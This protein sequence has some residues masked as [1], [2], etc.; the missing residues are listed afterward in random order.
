MGKMDLPK[1]VLRTM[2]EE[3]Y[4]ASIPVARKQYAAI[5]SPVALSISLR[6][7]RHTQTTPT[8]NIINA[9]DSIEVPLK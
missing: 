3:R 2:A 9:V 5:G 8:S 6:S 4:S 1:A 7:I